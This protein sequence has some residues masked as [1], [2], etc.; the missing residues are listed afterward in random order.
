MDEA[1][2]VPI[3]FVCNFPEVLALGAYYEDIVTGLQQS[4]LLEVDLEN[5]TLRLKEGWQKW[6][7]PNGK[8]GFGLPRYIRQSDNSATEHSAPTQQQRA[9]S[10]SKELSATASEYVF[11]PSSPP[12]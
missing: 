8:G 9:R 10:G 1:G 2:Y 5:E 12:K 11:A 3:A 7:I 4:A 6:L